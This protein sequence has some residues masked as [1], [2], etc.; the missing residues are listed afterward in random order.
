[1]LPQRRAQTGCALVRDNQA[2]RPFAR[3]LDNSDVLHDRMR[4]GLLDAML[5]IPTNPALKEESSA[6]DHNAKTHNADLRQTK[7]SPRAANTTT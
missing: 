1:M 7:A 4:T 3:S 5:P 2:E 6:E